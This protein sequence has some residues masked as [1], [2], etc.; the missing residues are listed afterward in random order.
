MEL[1]W[2]NPKLWHWCYSHLYPQNPIKRDAAPKPSQEQLIKQLQWRVESVIS[3]GDWWRVSWAGHFQKRWPDEVGH[4]CNV[5]AT[6]TR[7]SAWGPAMAPLLEIMLY[8]FYR[9]LCDSSSRFAKCFNHAKGADDERRSPWHQWL[10]LPWLCWGWERRH[11]GS[12]IYIVRA[13]AIQTRERADSN[14]L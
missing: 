5:L 13:R 6:I 10:P 1:K 3:Q 2:A 4:K 12:T 7:W 9:K 8:Y 11:E 14:S